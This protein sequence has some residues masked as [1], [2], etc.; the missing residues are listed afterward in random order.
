[1]TVDVSPEAARTVRPAEVGR[2]RLMKFVAEFGQGGTERQFINLALGLDHHSFLVEFG[3]MRRRGALADELDARGIRVHEYPIRS[4][5]D[6]RT[7][8]AQMRFGQHLRHEAT[9]I[10]HAYNFYGNVFAVPVARLAGVP[11]VVASIRDMGV[12]LDAA[13]R[14]VQRWACRFADRILV[15]AD[16]VRRWL[17][18]DGYDGSRIGV[19]PNGIDLSRFEAR[20]PPS[21]LRAE[22]G[23]GEATRIVLVVSRLVPRK[24]IEHFLEA[25]ARIAR[26]LEDVCFVVV[27][28]P[29]TPNLRPDGTSEPSFRHVLEAHAIRLGVGRRVIFTGHRRDIPAL[30]A[31]ASVSV[32]PSLS[33]GLSN[34]LLESMAM[35]A[36]VVATRVG[37]APEVIEDG[38][39]GLLVPPGAPAELARAVLVL[40]SDPG[41][42]RRLGRAARAL[43]TDRYGLERMVDA[44]AREYHQILDRSARRQA[45]PR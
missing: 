16:A 8:L 26:Q 12:Y 19:I 5:Y 45:V 42:A 36:P 29:A 44:T 13:Q 31:E 34:V 2:L 27:G 18:Q 10:V 3:C 35:A 14:R 40:L 28:E 23:L 41:R 43:V 21:S 4:F 17:I 22:Y 39:T 1:M 11:A 9:D 30:M 6:P 20:P 33:E 38:G 25:A 24:G 37:G 15:N 7:A 32:L